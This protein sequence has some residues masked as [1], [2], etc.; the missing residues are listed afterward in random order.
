MYEYLL[1]GS[2]G[3]GGRKAVS[4]HQESRLDFLHRHQ[5][6]AK[7]ALQDG[8]RGVRELAPCLLARIADSRTLALAWEYLAL[9]GGQAPGPNG[10]RYTDYNQGEVWALCKCLAQAVRDG[11][12]YPGPERTVMINKT[13]GNG[14]R[15][16]VMIN[17]EDRVVQ[18][19][20]VMILQPLLDPL[21]DSRSMGYRPQLGHLHAL[22]LGE[23][24]TLHERRRVWV[25]QDITDAF[26]HVQ[27][28]RLL[29]VVHKLLPDKAL[30]D[31]LERILP[32]RTLN[33]LRQGGPLS[34]MMLNKYL[35][36]FLDRPWRRDR[37]HQPLIRVAD[38]LLIP[39]RS[40]KQANQAHA[41]LSALMLPAGMPLKYAVADAIHDFDGG[42][43]VGWLGFN[44][45]KAERGLAAEIGIKS[46]D[47]L[48]ECLALAHTKSDAPLRAI[49]GIKQWLNHRGPCYPWSN[50]KK[51]CQRIIDIAQLQGFEEVPQPSEL[52][53]R[54]QRAY[55][56]WCRV[57]K[58]VR[59]ACQPQTE[60]T[61]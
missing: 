49:Y 58:E 6:N 55:A 22:A 53:G 46:W 21:F 19:A 34:P 16:I 37:P 25:T 27:V 29:Q 33:G 54:W 3:L 59:R 42:E 2:I 57:R 44:I 48:E 12:Y 38:D 30:I 7:R 20:V 17:I 35:D 47:R 45:S 10:H 36:H 39:C 50:R 60:M 24:L 40:E 32:A 1:R 9:K 15:P 23:F 43:V 4:Y 61:E 41:T 26:Q 5:E 28:S 31:L 14:Q 18:R 11:R 51:D 52:L 56:R 13:S 8:L